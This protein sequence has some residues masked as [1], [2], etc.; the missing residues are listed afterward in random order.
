MSD[1]NLLQNEDFSGVY[2]PYRKDERIQTPAGWAPWWVSQREG[3]PQWQN[4]TPEF[5]PFMLDDR[6]V[7][8]VQSPFA[9]HTAGL[10]QQVPAAPGDRYELVTET[11]AWSS[12]DDAAGSRVEAGDV[13]VQIG[14]DPTGGV[15]PMSPLVQWSKPQ[16]PISEWETI[17]LVF[18]AEATIITVFLKSAPVAPKRQQAVFWAKATVRPLGKYRRSVSIVGPG[19]THIRLEPDEPRPGERAIVVVSS[20]RDHSFI[21]LSIERPDKSAAA[22]TSLGMNRVGDRFTWRYAFTPVQAGLYDIRFVGDRGARLLAQQLLR[23]SEEDVLAAQAHEAPSGQARVDYQRTYVLLPPTADVWW[24]VAAARGSFE[25][26][27][28]TGYSA[29][30]AGVGELTGRHVLAV[31]PHHWPEPLSASWFHRNYPGTRF[32]PVVANSPE[33]LEAWLRDWVDDA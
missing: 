1:K 30:D 22:T 27:Y 18:E 5:M 3:D 14:V 28:S 7:Q 2:Y 12:E 25:G 15:D 24:A 8:R 19:D 10:V 32:T 23:V 21:D 17:R 4:K 11:Q 20:V 9:T 31:N 16:Q 13:N 33:D 26:R 29:D 6:P